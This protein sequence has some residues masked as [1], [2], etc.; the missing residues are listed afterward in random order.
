MVIF[1]LY[2]FFLYDLLESGFY[3]LIGNSNILDVGFKIGVLVIL[4]FIFCEN[5]FLFGD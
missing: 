4:L 5:F 2:W 3:V 1:L